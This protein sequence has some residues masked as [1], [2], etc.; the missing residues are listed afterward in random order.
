MKRLFVNT[1]S[2]ESGLN[3]DLDGN[4]FNYL[5]KVL[6]Y[7][8]LDE[9]SVF[10][11]KDGDFRAAITK[12]EKK[13]LTIKILEKIREQKNVSNLTLA[14]ALPKNVKIDFIAQ[15]ATEL[16]INAFQPIITNHTI[17]DKINYNRFRAN[18]KE[19]CEQCERNHIPEVFLLKKLEKFLDECLN[20]KILI[21]C[22]E[23]GK[24][25]RAS[26][27]FLKIPREDVLNKGIIIL[28][29]PE[30]GFSKEEFV[31]LRIMKNLYSMS[32][33]NTILRCDTAAVVAIALVQE[34][35]YYTNEL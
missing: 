10:N 9:I 26:S 11:G 13:S 24:G 16:G 31:R 17:V 28:I 15:K 2:L 25:L 33:G 30:G 32:L 19:A 6:R 34:V 29:G 21:L 12:V 18:V 22:D 4:D 7:K 3:I 35:F 23:E 27:L 14:F 20:N 8:I 1:K 5:A